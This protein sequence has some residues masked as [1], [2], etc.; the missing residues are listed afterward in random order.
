MVELLVVCAAMTIVMAACY[1]I[2]NTTMKVYVN[3]I[4]ASRTGMAMRGIYDELALDIMQ[5]PGQYA[6]GMT[7]STSGSPR[8]LEDNSGVP[9]PALALGRVVAGP[10]L[11]ENDLTNVKTFTSV[12]LMYPPP[13]T[14]GLSQTTT[15]APYGLAAQY[16]N[17]IKVG[18]YL[19]L[20]IGDAAEARITAVTYN[21]ASKKW[22][23]TCE[24][25]NISFATNP[26]SLTDGKTV[27]AFVIRYSAYAVLRDMSLYGRTFDGLV[28]YD[29]LE[30]DSRR[31]GK[32]YNPPGSFKLPLN[33]T[34]SYTDLITTDIAAS[35]T[36][37]LADATYANNVKLGNNPAVNSSLYAF[38]PFT[39]VIGAADPEV[40]IK[41]GVEASEY[42]GANESK[43]FYTTAELVTKVPLK[44]N[45]L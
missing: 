27:P 6:A 40:D 7:I 29:G 30:V 16:D 15:D 5:S 35:H 11:V 34:T 36:A 24:T 12:T 45:G 10:L 38:T 2:F 21:T 44:S 17:E 26:T 31:G 14:S 3:G 13:V 32:A 19:K 39:T 1:A 22:A 9:S 41:L 37:G 18:D 42:D 43:P 23:I 33:H 20:P 4:S 8:K 25:Y 28:Y